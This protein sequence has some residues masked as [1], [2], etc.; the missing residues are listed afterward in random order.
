M[1][2]LRLDNKLTKFIS[3]FTLFTE[4]SMNDDRTLIALSEVVKYE[5]HQKIVELAKKLEEAEAKIAEYEAI[6]WIHQE[7]KGLDGY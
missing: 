4:V 6:K 3:F 1:L 7:F 2:L 5:H